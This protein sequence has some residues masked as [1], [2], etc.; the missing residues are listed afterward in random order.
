MLCKIREMRC[1]WFA[2]QIAE[3][4]Y[5]YLFFFWQIHQLKARAA[6][7]EERLEVPCI[8]VRSCLMQIRV[9]CNVK[10]LQQKETA[11]SAEAK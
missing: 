9:Q 11:T 7:A 5:V 2:T 10:V 1:R 3:R 8:K 4:T 6:K